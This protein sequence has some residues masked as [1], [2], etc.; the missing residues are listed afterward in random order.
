M[1]KT[2]QN[3]YSHIID[4][5]NLLSAYENARKSKQQTGAMRLFHF[6]LERNLW[7]LHLELRDGTYRPGPYHNFMIFEPKPRKISAASFRDRI[8]HHALCQVIQPLFERKFIFDSYANRV[9]KGNHKALDRAHAWV[10]QY[11][12]VL[13]ADLRKFFPSIDHAVLMDV[14]RRTLACPPTLALC[15]RI[16]D[17]GAGILADEYPLQ[18]FPG[19]DLFT[20]LQRERGLPIGN[21]TSQFWGNALLNELDHFVKEQLRVKAYLRYVDDFLLFG[22][23]KA[24]LWAAHAAIGAFLAGLRLSLHP[25]KC[26]VMPTARGVA[27]LGFRLFPTHRRLLGDSLR[28]AHKRLRRQR[29]ALARGELTPEAL[30]RSLASW[31]GHARHGNTYQLRALLLSGV[32]WPIGRPVQPPA[33]VR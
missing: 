11:P 20:P 2:Y 33:E 7:D 21:L 5:D 18:W 17:S 16:V 22:H 3:L 32:V 10:K 23:S 9:G 12:Y 19:D 31:I 29:R 15:R 13:K 6:N 30:R 28:R 25:H 8:V 27:F 14:L 4:F 26:H 24:E 1:P